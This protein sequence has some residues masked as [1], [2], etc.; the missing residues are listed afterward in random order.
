LSSLTHKGLGFIEKYSIR[1]K[2]YVDYLL[3][4][5]SEYNSKEIDIE[6]SE[7]EASLAR[8]RR[9]W[10]NTSKGRAA[11][12]KKRY[13]T[14]ENNG[15]KKYKNK[16]PNFKTLLEEAKQSASYQ[17]AVNEADDWVSKGSFEPRVCTSVM[18]IYRYAGYPEKAESLLQELGEKS[19]KYVSIIHYNTVVSAF[20]DAGE[21]QR[22]LELLQQL[23]QHQCYGLLPDEFTYSAALSALDK[24]SGVDPEI[25]MDLLRLMEAR[26]DETGTSSGVK[27]SIVRPT[28]WHY[29]SVISAFEKEGR[30]ETALCLLDRM[31]KRGVRLN[32]VVYNAVMSAAVKGKQTEVCQNLF[33]EMQERRLRCD[34]ITYTTLIRSYEIGGHWQAAFDI[35]DRMKREGVAPNDASFSAVF[36]AC[37]RSAGVI[38][39]EKAFQLFMTVP[40]RTIRNYNAMISVLAHAGQWERALNLFESIGSI[41]SIDYDVYTYAAAITA[42]KVSNQWKQAIIIWKKMEAQGTAL[43]AVT[44]T[45]LISILGNAGRWKE[46]LKLFESFPNRGIEVSAI[47][48]TATIE[49]LTQDRKGRYFGPRIEPSDLE[50]ASI[51]PINTEE[52]ETSGVLGGLEGNFRGSIQVCDIREKK[53][54]LL[55]QEALSKGYLKPFLWPHPEGTLKEAHNQHSLTLDFHGHTLSVSL[56]IIKVLLMDIQLGTRELTDI[57]IITGKG[58]HENSRGERGTLKDE[59]FRSLRELESNNGA[60][61]KLEIVYEEKNDGRM[62]IKKDAIRQF[63]G[64]G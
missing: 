45:L 62:R 18:N 27:T 51:T 9:P 22:A 5:K 44:A 7:V 35:L 54:F 42:C 49:A 4:A 2:P 29:A 19:P 38:P 55:V 34:T 53:A 3:A 43:N 12:S 36:S 46:A 33:N 30:W 47:S 21:W 25:S 24:G 59:L 39:W 8:A 63:L 41:E 50:I 13:S 57:L 31:K 28:E 10:E 23:E 14:N 48:I 60:Q 6:K 56:L 58:L 40:F 11:L 26:A 16:S 17:Y 37:Q 20:A 52:C 1:Q 61:C 32:T 15:P 64:L